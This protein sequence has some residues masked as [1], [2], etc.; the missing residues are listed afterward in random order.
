MVL[1]VLLVIAESATY[2]D[3]DVVRY[4]CTNYYYSVTVIM[5]ATHPE[6]V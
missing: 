2:L 1:L 4:M 6:C 5:A 3:H